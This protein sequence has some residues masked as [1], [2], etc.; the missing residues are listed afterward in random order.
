MLLIEGDE[1]PPRRGLKRIAD[2]SHAPSQTRHVTPAVSMHE[3]PI[4]AFKF[5][6]GT[7]LPDAPAM[8]QSALHASRQAPQKLQCDLPK[9]TIG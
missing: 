5:Q 8:K 2:V 4:T 7:S 9:S 1:P 3:A 6:G